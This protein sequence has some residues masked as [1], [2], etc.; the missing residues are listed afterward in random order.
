MID[1]ESEIFAEV[2]DAVTDSFPGTFMTGE[3]ARSPSEFPCVSLVEIEN[4]IHVGSSTNTEMEVHAD[5][6]YEV[7]VY[8]NKQKGKRDECKKIASLVDEKLKDMGFRRAMLNPVP[9]LEDATIYR[10]LGRYQAV[11]EVKN[12]I[13]VIYRR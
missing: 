2:Y 7:N 10:M 1:A 8:S 3:Y 5:V 4:V 13:I 12:D 11:I 6:T 9:N